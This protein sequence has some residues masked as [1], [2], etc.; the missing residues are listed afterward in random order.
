MGFENI[1]PQK[2]FN[3]HEEIKKAR[4]EKE[5]RKITR[6]EAIIAGFK[7]AA[8]LAVGTTA[9]KGTEK[10]ISY[11][12]EL[13]EKL[14]E[15]RKK[16]KVT[17]NELRSLR[18]VLHKKY[19]ESEQDQ[20]IEPQDILPKELPEEEITEEI[21]IIEEPSP[22][23]LGEEK[24][25]DFAEAL[26]FESKQKIVLDQEFIET[27]EEYYFDRF[28]QDGKEHE[29]MTKSYTNMGQ[30]GLRLLKQPFEERN[31]P[32]GLMGIAIIESDGG[33][34][35][36]L[37]NDKKGEFSP[38]GWHQISKMVGS[39]KDWGEL[40]INKTVDERF[41]PIKSNEAC[42]KIIKESLKGCNNDLRLAIAG[43]NGG[44]AWDYN[45][46][47][48]VKERSF[49][50]FLKEIENEIN[51]YKK[52][53]K[54]KKEY[55]YTVQDG[56]T[57]SKIAD[58]FHIKSYN[59]LA[60]LNKLKSPDD[61][62]PNQEIKIPLGDM[63]HRKKIFNTLIGT[64]GLLENIPY[65]AQVM[66]TQKIIDNGELDYLEVAKIRKIEPEEYKTRKEA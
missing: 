46:E 28:K 33:T 32:P 51:H 5:G 24:E 7:G 63:E 55:I 8:A 54:D 22:E 62:D 50:A 39:K 66:A 25:I 27:Y 58:K 47:T 64:A 2:D 61:I 65:V 12:G 14:L 30:E 29:K 53:L 6:R 48:P 38:V 44:F 10:A 11:A 42:A 43:Y 13:K 4:Q 56:E 16:R 59:T 45:E 23:A 17:N 34:N 52:E 9:F 21:K 60:K 40:T 31:L 15:E 49:V 36:E 20:E 26:D 37:K 19:K 41:Y 1:S 3:D 57:L 18:E 35:P